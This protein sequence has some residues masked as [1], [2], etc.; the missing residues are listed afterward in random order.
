MASTVQAS[1]FDPF[2]G[3]S[4]CLNLGSLVVIIQDIVGEKCKKLTDSS[5]VHFLYIDD[6]TYASFYFI[7]LNDTS[8]SSKHKTKSKI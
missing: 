1:S 8:Q 4:V 3:R 6:H 5:I 2:Y 7:A